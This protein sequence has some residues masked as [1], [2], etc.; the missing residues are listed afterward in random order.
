[1]LAV[2]RNTEYDGSSSSEA[3]SQ[4]SILNSQCITLANIEKKDGS[5][6]VTIHT[7]LQTEGNAG[8]KERGN[9]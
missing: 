7:R 3:Y 5:L 4:E 8:E 2:T 1:M 6:L 9:Q